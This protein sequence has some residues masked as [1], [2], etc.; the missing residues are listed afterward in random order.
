MV[1]GA[2]GFIGRATVVQLLASGH[3]VIGVGRS[4]RADGTFTH[5]VSWNGR[6]LPAP[7]LL[8]HQE[9]LAGSA[10]TYARADL[11]DR[12][13]ITDLLR[14]HQPDVVI[15]LAAALRD[16]A[17]ERL[18]STNIGTIASLLDAIVGAGVQRPRMVF[19]SSGSVYGVVPGRPLPL[20]EHHPCAPV[21]PYAISKRA[22]EDL[23][24]VIAGELGIPSLWARIFNP[25][26]PGQDERHLCG[27]LGQQ[28]A[29]MVAGVRP[30]RLLVGPLHTTRDYQHVE[31]TARALACLAE[32]G[33]PG[34][35]YNVASG[36]ETPGTAVLDVL[37]AR[38]G[39]TGR[40]EIDR[41]PPRP[42]DMERHFADV[43]KLEALGFRPESGLEEALSQVLEY[44][45]DIVA[46]PSAATSDRPPVVRANPDAER[47]HLVSVGVEQHH[48]YDIET[49]TGLRHE[50]PR[51]LAGRYP[52]HPLAVFTDHRVHELYG[53]DLIDGLR[54]EGA[55][56]VPILV[57]AGEASK[58]PACVEQAIADMREA[59]IDRRSVV[60]NLGGGVV[61]DLGGFV[62][63]TYL[64][65]IPYV[66]VA[67][68]LLAQHDSAIGGKVAI[69]A[70]WAK[71]FVGAFHHPIAVFNDPEMLLTLA[72]QDLAAGVAE[73][74]KLGV[75]GVPDLFEWLESTSAEQLY[76][77]AKLL[78][79]LVVRS[80]AGKVALLEPDPHE[81][82][83]RRVLNL[84]HTF[85]HPLETQLDY[86]GILHGEAVGF[87]IAVATAIGVQLRLLDPVD[88][89][90]I[91]RLLRSHSLPP[92]VS[93]HDLLAA[94]KGFDDV[95]LVRAGA[96][97][98]VVP[99]SVSSVEILEDLPAG[100]V[101]DSIDWLARHPLTAGCIT[102]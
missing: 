63:A 94:V 33:E 45:L 58:S 98:F 95:R 49:V 4:E 82:D 27:W 31:D 50:L 90:R 69:N 37:A 23:S 91:L 59:G 6:Q 28:I 60:V 15:H 64:R 66:N 47:R 20:E 89:D 46:R 16:E 73:S 83:L 26:G 19:G 87:G 35:V 48:S 5:S 40:I 34:E 10:Y 17:P 42:S 39:L 36:V 14:R 85:G 29:E 55:T 71:N 68:T 53:R 54:A 78:S 67:T 7:T 88:A 76:V 99:T 97:N 62:A 9:A 100:A 56:V 96:L 22:A 18:V 61:T 77:D 25:V 13:R 51:L 102:G 24:R 38:G 70:P 86:R 92:E 21:D 30:R 81:V 57:P 93:V 1:T 11:L 2:Q 8:A 43:S 41:K 44:Y 101:Q 74:V 65:G 52:G 75:C 80:A 3:R 79:E 12:V 32:R 72:R 84:G